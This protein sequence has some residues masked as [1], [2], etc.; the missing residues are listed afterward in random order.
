MNLPGRA[1]ASEWAPGFFNFKNGKKVMPKNNDYM[2][3]HLEQLVGQTITGL[4]QDKDEPEIVGFQTK[5]F[6]VWVLCDPEGNGPGFLEIEKKK[7][8]K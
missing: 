6:D 2:L 4:L 8:A 7:G 3:K 5:S 1:P